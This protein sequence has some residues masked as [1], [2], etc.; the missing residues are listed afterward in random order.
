MVTIYM[1][2]RRRGLRRHRPA[3]LLGA[4]QPARFGQGKWAI[5]APVL[6]LGGIY[7]GAFTPTEAAGVAVFYA[8]FVGV[9]STAS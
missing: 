1:I 4:P 2:A 9:L 7:S 3:V 6:I 8:L 5:G